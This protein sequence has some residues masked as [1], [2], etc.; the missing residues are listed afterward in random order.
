MTTSFACELMPGDVFLTRNLK[1]E[2]NMTPGWY[3]HSA[4]YVGNEQVVEAQYGQGVIVTPLKTFWERYP[5]V[6]VLRCKTLD[7]E[8]RAILIQ[9]AKGLVGRPYNIFGSWGFWSFDFRAGRGDNCVAVI[10][11]CFSYAFEYDPGWVFPDGIARDT[12]NMVPFG[13]KELEEGVP[14]P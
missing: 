14:V 5:Y 4:I 11:R 1:E 8:K 7:E 3:N 10:R 9:V 12:F 13:Y 6:V 2:D